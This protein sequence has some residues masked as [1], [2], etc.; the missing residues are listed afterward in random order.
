MW[1]GVSF[2][3]ACVYALNELKWQMLYTGY[4]GLGSCYYDNKKN[5]YWARQFYDNE[6][7]ARKGFG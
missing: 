7:D 4:Q 3:Q 1:E 2:K 6:E 5:T